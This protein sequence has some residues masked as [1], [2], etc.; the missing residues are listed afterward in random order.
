MKADQTRHQLE[1]GQLALE[2][3]AVLGVLEVLLEELLGES[4][5]VVDQ[6]QR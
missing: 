5:R 2:G 3:K 6:V 4:L 1:D